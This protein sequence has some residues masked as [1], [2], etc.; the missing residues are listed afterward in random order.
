MVGLVRIPH[1]PFV[2]AEIWYA[3]I[4]PTDLVELQL[5]S[6]VVREEPSRLSVVFARP[7]RCIS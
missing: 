5:S 6:C 3:A 4:P 1:L 2:W 7:S